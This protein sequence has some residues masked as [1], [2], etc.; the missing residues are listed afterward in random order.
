MK[1][2]GHLDLGFKLFCSTVRDGALSWFG[3]KFFVAGH[4]NGESLRDKKPSAL[5]VVCKDCTPIEGPVGVG[6][7]PTR[8]DSIWREEAPIGLSATLKLSESM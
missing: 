6:N 8:E 4:A 1:L 2:S 5:V 7:H 3:I